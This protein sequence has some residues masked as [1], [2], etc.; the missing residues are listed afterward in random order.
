M[1]PVT[2]P[3]NDLEIRQHD[4]CELDLAELRFS[5]EHAL[6]VAR[7]H[8]HEQLR[9]DGPIRQQFARER[10]LRVP[11]MALQQVLYELRVAIFLERLELD[12]FG[13]AAPWKCRLR[14]VDVRD[15]ATHACRE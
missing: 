14:I 8:F 15:A 5:F 11:N 9:G 7:H 3:M 1:K 6:V 4:W 10:A 2:L 13:I 12:E